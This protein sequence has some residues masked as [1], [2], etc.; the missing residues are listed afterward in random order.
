M[1]NRTQRESERKGWREVDSPVGDLEGETLPAV[2][3][4]VEQT[5]GGES[6]GPH[7]RGKQ[8]RCARGE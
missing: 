2:T 7:T 8:R 4:V 6:R 5:E 1:G 3:V